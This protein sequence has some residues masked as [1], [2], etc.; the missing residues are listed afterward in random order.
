MLSK[1]ILLWNVY[2]LKSMAQIQELTIWIII[3]SFRN[4][5][6]TMPI[7]KLL[8]FD[9]LL[10]K[11]LTA[12]RFHLPRTGK[13]RIKY[14]F[15]ICVSNEKMSNFMAEC[16]KADANVWIIFDTHIQIMFPHFLI[17]ALF[18]QQNRKCE[19]DKRFFDTKDSSEHTKCCFF[20]VCDNTSSVWLQ[21]SSPNSLAQYFSTAAD[22]TQAIF[23]TISTFM[24]L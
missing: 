23:L 3:F 12:K 21:K 15:L 22:H 20:L 10:I 1:K 13:L 4:K 17:S 14:L 11:L 19:I 2:Y 7:K 16:L 9:L 6:C 8:R 18:F 24:N 5:L